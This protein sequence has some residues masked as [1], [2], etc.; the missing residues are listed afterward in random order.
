[1][2][3][4][5]S[6]SLTVH[7]PHRTVDRPPLDEVRADLSALFRP[8]P[9]LLTPLRHPTGCS[10]SRAASPSPSAPTSRPST[11]TRSPRP[12]R[13][14]RSSR[15]PMPSRPRRRRCRRMTSR[16]VRRLPCPAPRVRSRRVFSHFSFRYSLRVRAEVRAFPACF[17]PMFP[18]SLSPRSPASPRPCSQPGYTADNLS[19]KGV[20]TQASNAAAP[21]PR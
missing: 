11:R 19:E 3:A 6:Q 21:L 4:Q 8:A 12:A 5:C 10:T 18:P 20:G 15:W 16:S 2:I 9:P 7:P 14:T 13:P 17:K 1:M